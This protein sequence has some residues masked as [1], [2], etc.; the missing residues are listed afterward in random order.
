[1]GNTDDARSRRLARVV[2]RVMAERIL[3]FN[4]I[5]DWKFGPTLCQ[6]SLLIVVFSERQQRQ[7]KGNYDTCTCQT[8]SAAKRPVI[9]HSVESCA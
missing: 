8:A 5:D 3:W 1:M 6:V 4:G 2:D 7:Q 9:V